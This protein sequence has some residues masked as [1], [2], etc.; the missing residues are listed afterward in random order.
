MELNNRVTLVSGFLSNANNRE[1][2]NT[3]EYIRNG[4]LFLKSTTPK[5]VF[6]DEEMFS[7][8]NESDYDPENTK[9]VLYGKEQMYY[10]NYVDKIEHLP[11]TDNPS[12]NTKLFL[13]IMWNKTEYMKE[14]TQLNPFNTDYYVWMDFGIRYVC[15]ESTDQEF[16]EK[17]NNIRQPVLHNKVRIG[18]IWNINNIYTTDLINEPLWYFA[19][20]VFGGNRDSLLF[21]SEEMKKASYELVTKHKIAT[22]EVNVWYVIYKMIPYLFDI[23]PSSH[24]ETL[25]DGYS[26]ETPLTNFL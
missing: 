22:W 12:K 7:Q 11:I 1:F 19:G 3:G 14:A 21:F 23:Y 9:L 13:L 18:G 20:G 6:L 8:I 16:V 26:T 10:M 15:K 4:K 2:H 5:I 25:I 24:D 17:L